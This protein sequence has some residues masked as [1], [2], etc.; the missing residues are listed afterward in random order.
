MSINSQPEHLHRSAIHASRVVCCALLATVLLLSGCNQQMDNQPRLDPLESSDF[1]TDGKASRDL[2]PGTVARGHSPHEI[3]S[4]STH[5]LTGSTGEGVA[6]TLPEE[7]TAD[8]STAELLARGQ[9]RY[10]IYCSHCH[11]L[12]GTGQG[13]VPQRGFPE[14]PTF[15]SDRLR[16][17]SLGHFFQVIQHGHGNMPAHGGQVPPADRWAIAAYLRALQ[18]SQH[19]TAEQLTP[20]D[21]N[22]LQAQD[23]PSTP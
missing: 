14:P 1:F 18:L 3:T 17:A 10:E 22:Q 16:A 6:T 2:V 8:W 7:I 12:Q 15:H 13:I 20:A 11:D 5:Y 19:A 9:Q 23:Q 4:H 21:M